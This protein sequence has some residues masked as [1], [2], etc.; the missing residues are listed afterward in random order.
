MTLTYILDGKTAKPEPNPAT[1][2]A[3][4]RAALES[5]TRVVAKSRVNAQLT[6]STV[7][8]GLDQR[9][10]ESPSSPHPVLFETA[11]FKASEL[12]RTEY[13]TDW[14]EAE[15]AHAGLVAELRATQSH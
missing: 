15:S 1:W 11:V 4:M 8:A 13:H 6:V 7:F 12:V 2:E 14:S 3:W 10:D 5:G 9:L